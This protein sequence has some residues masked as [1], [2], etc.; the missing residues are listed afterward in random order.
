MTILSARFVK[1]LDAFGRETT[2]QYLA[3]YD[4]MGR[5]LCLHKDSLDDQLV[6]FLAQ[7][8]SIDPYLDAPLDPTAPVLH[9]LVPNQ[10]FVGDPDLTLK[11]MGEGF[12]DKSVIV[13]N[14]ADEPT[15]FVSE[16]QLETGVKPSTAWGPI[17]IEVYVRTGLAKTGTSTRKLYFSFL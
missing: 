13:W 3:A 1:M 4:D 15:T 6:R 2:D 12:T 9:A 5:V 11:V 14:N 17:T 16:T 10:A 7:P 8:N